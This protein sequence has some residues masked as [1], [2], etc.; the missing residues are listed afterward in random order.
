MCGI[1]GLIEDAGQGNQERLEFQAEAMANALHH[2]GPDSAG[3]WADGTTG[4]AL[5]FRRLSIIDLSVAGDQ[6]MRSDDGRY[7]ITFNGEIYNFAAIRSVLS[8]HGVRFRSQSDTEVLLKACIHWGVERAVGDMVGMF[9]FALWDN[10]ERK[11]WVVRDRLGIKPVYFGRAGD[12][13]VFASELKALRTLDDW[14]PEID[15]DA[16]SLFTQFNYVPAPQTIYKGISKLEPGC[17]L[18]YKAGGTPKISRYWNI[19][20]QFQQ[21]LLD[22]GER[23]AVW[24]IDKLL[25]DAVAQRLVSD[26]PLGALLSGGI[27]SSTVVALMNRSTQSSVRTFT[28]GFGD[29]GYDEAGTAK[30]IANHIGTDHTE[31]TLAPKAALDLIANMPE[32]YDEPFA[33][34]SALPTYLVSQ[35]ARQH[36]TVALSGDGGDEIF[37]GYNRYTAAPAIWRRTSWLPQFLRCIGGCAIKTI[38]PTLWDRLAH[39]IPEARRPRTPGVKMHKVGDI[40]GQATEK[41]AYRSLVSHWSGRSLIKNGR[42]DEISSW[43]DG[44]PNDFAAKMALQDTCTYLPDDILAKVDRSS[45][46]VGLEVRVPLLDHRIVELMARLP[47]ELKLKDGTPKYLLRQ[48]LRQYVPET[49]FER[50][51]MGF[52]VPLDQW[53]RGP[54][55]DWAEDLLDERRLA[56]EGWFEPKRVR[57]LWRRHLKGAGNNQETLWGVLMAQAWLGRW[58]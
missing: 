4:A 41:D 16:F 19:R 26:V 28:I 22:I 44:L 25:S 32:T 43:P 5:G 1:A 13:F 35:L 53:L 38:N 51:K 52:A 30:Q 48:V 24:Q 58:A 7:A 42:Q 14:S 27:D 29:K 56:D 49:L 34:S 33:D 2:R 9:A 47:T 50:P 15:R 10:Q 3:V 31:M 8:S 54:L 23:E 11:L 46:A 55:R 20:S 39:M 17:M 6:P 36:V 57:R 12:R 37:Y 45:M 18:E 21:P 40:L